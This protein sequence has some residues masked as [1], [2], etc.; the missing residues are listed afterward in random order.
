MA[1]RAARGCSP[2]ERVEVR[3]DHDVRVSY[4]LEGQGPA[5]GGMRLSRVLTFEVLPDGGA[6]LELQRCDVVAETVV[7]G[8]E[9]EPHLAPCGHPLGCGEPCR[10][11]D[12]VEAAEEIV[13]KLGRAYGML[14]GEHEKLRARVA[15][16]ISAASTGNAMECERL[17]KEL[18]RA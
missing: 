6:K 4:D 17:M 18:G 15:R 9:H 13:E 3:L 1:Q 2:G 16:L 12:D 14:R 10:W 11:C 8:A 5:A 7:T